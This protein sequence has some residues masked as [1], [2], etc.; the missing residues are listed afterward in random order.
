MRTLQINCNIDW[1]LGDPIS[2]LC[3]FVRNSWIRHCRKS[4]VFAIGW[5]LPTFGAAAA[6]CASSLLK[7]LQGMIMLSK[8]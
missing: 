5:I 6:E 8:A 4:P 1:L 3:K 2:T 7:T